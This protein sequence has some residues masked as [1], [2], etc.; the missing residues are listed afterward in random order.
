MQRLTRT[1]ARVCAAVVACGTAV[2]IALTVGVALG[3][4]DQ[5]AQSHIRGSV[6]STQ[7]VPSD[8]ASSYGF[9]TSPSAIALPA[10]LTSQIDGSG[11]GINP[12]LGREAGSVKTERLWLIPGSSG[13]CI[14]IDDGGSACGSNTLVEQ[15]GAWL[16]LQPVSGATVTVYGIV[17]DGAT[18]SGD[19]ASVSRSANAVMVAPNSSAPADFTIHTAGGA[20]V[21]LP[22]AAATGQP[23]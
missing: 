4:N 6:V 20:N 1:A 18:V 10:G 12:S 8:L 21:T 13:S 15:Q 14:E 11:Y 2:G 3:S 7:A 17:P 23:Q 19:G 16:I 9:L 5:P 22:I